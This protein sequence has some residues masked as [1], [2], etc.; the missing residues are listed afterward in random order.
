MDVQAVPAP[1]DA[2][3]AAAP[4]VA[5]CGRHSRSYGI[6]SAP[7]DGEAAG[8]PSATLILVMG[9]PGA[10]EY[11]TMFAEWADRWRR[12]AES[13]DVSVVEIG[14]GE[15]GEAGDRARLSEAIA[16]EAD[17]EI[18]PLWIVLIGH[19]TFDGREAK[20]NL[21]GPDVPAGELA[22]SL[23]EIRRPV[24]VINCASSSGAF[25]ERLSAPGR[26]I[27]TATRNGNETNFS[28]F[29]DYLSQSISGGDA[30]F[31][32]DGQ[33]SL[34]EAF[35]SASRLT[36]EFYE[37][38]DRIPTEHALIDDDGDG[39]G[40][41]AE[42]FEGIRPV[43]D[44]VTGALDGYRAHQWQLVPGEVERNFPVELRARRDE[45][46]LEV[47]KLRDRKSEMSEA[48]YFGK[49]EPLL[50]EL[51]ELYERAEEE[52]GEERSPAGRG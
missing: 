49:L 28:R 9:E 1:I 51:A 23:E 24:A 36:R 52:S 33:V 46:E 32:K 38:E 25:L 6:A 39:A 14:R 20:F 3:S 17:E 22:D 2:F 48:E 40:T 13:G 42:A 10:D 19:G 11:R 44:S 4:P 43:R 34:L 26:V 31:D 16:N 35:L 30:D 29:G 15:V 41:R 45:L 12:A 27:V 18:R 47:F 50:I 5:F 8:E 37:S 7:E 21:R